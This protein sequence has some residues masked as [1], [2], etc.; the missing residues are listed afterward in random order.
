MAI[1][2]LSIAIRRTFPCAGRVTITQMTPILCC[3]GLVLFK[4]LTEMEKVSLEELK[5]QGVTVPPPPT[6]EKVKVPEPSIII[7]TRYDKP[8]H[9]KGTDTSQVDQAEPSTESG[10]HPT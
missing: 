8:I 3:R 6:N 7:R 10:S 4:D 5:E 2:R 1:D 9:S